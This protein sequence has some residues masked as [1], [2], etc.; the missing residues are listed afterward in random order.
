MTALWRGFDSLVPTGPWSVDS[1]SR[2]GDNDAWWGR[3]VSR[4]IHLN[5]PVLDCNIRWVGN[6]AKFDS[7]KDIVNRSVG[8]FREH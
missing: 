3:Q 6:Y 2:R 5:D 8:G 7:D 1:S 4:H